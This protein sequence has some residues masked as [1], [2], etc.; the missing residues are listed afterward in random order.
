MLYIGDEVMNV[1]LVVVDE[2]TV[3]FTLWFQDQFNDY[4]SIINLLN[5]SAYHSCQQNIY[6]KTSRQDK[7]NQHGW[8]TT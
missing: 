7:E 3:D 4:Y 8:L 1:V 6:L 5:S 2:I